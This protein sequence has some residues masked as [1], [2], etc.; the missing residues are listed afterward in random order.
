MTAFI[1]HERYS[2]SLIQSA[3]LLL[4][5]AFAGIGRAQEPKQDERV[6]SEEN[7]NQRLAL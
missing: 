5:F 4:C 7:K 2:I 3:I 1:L 6:L